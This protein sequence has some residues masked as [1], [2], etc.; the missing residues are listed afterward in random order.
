M[1]I[2]FFLKITFIIFFNIKFINCYLS[3]G[4]TGESVTDYPC[5]SFFCMINLFDLVD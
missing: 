5:A 2:K 3:V 4:L 1:I